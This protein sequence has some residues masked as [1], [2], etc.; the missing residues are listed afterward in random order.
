MLGSD[1]EVEEVW[2]GA[3]FVMWMLKKQELGAETGSG[4]PVRGSVKRRTK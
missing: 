2:E 3:E 4:W 1:Q